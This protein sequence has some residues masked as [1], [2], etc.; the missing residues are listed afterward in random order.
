MGLA[1]GSYGTY[2]WP[3]ASHM[4][5]WSVG[6]CI[7]WI[8]FTRENNLIQVVASIYAVHRQKERKCYD[9]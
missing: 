5:Q 1:I 6:Y 9:P 4:P 3:Y 2:S 8:K 7:Q